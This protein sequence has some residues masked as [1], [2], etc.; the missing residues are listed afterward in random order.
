MRDI[1]NKSFK[2][3]VMQTI[4]LGQKM[5]FSIMQLK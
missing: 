3:Q 4:R 5:Q 2:P 1:V